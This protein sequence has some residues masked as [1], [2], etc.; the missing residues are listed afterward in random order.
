MVYNRILVPLDGS[1]HGSQAIP[2]A[3]ILGKGLGAKVEL[4]RVFD[5]QPEY[6]W[7]NPSEY[8]QRHQAALDFREQA[9]VDLESHRNSLQQEGINAIAL[10][11]GPEGG[12]PEGHEHGH[13][14]GA[15]AEHIVQQAGDNPDTVIL[16]STHGRSGIGRWAMGSTAE[17]VVHVAGCPV[18]LVRAHSETPIAAETALKN[19][20]VPTDGSALAESILPH[21]VG[22]SKALGS[23]VQLL[24]VTHEDRADADERDHL[25]RIADRL[26]GEGVGEVAV[27]VL[28]GDPATAIV[29]YIDKSPNSL[30]AM[31]SHGHSGLGR[32]VMG[33]VADRVVRHAAGPVLV[34]RSSH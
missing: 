25:L 15:P 14:Y 2:Y 23:R 33:G 1:E 3:R 8:L 34:L 4:F 12:A 24:R 22:L 11:H 29:E 30:L 16:M 5:P 19:I 26:T 27:E 6:F 9:M 18:I 20:V 32:W 28:N 13:R 17:K 10:V 31:T 7:P 21:V